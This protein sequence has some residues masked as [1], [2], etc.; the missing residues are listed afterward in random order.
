MHLWGKI[1]KVELAQPAGTRSCKSG[2]SWDWCR[3]PGRRNTNYWISEY[4][5]LL[6]T[7]S[8]ADGRVLKAELRRKMQA[9]E[10][11]GLVYGAK[12]DVVQMRIAPLI[13]EIRVRRNV[14]TPDGD[15]VV[16]LYFS[17]PSH[18]PQLL[19]AAKLGWKPPLDTT[20]QDEHA[21]EAQE[22]VKAFFP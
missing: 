20:E 7:C 19:L 10:A 14:G 1:V 8:P 6:R 21:L 18:E 11:G 4:E 3:A 5:A 22:R 16:R 15:R 9:A 12:R 2:G 17:E 13:L